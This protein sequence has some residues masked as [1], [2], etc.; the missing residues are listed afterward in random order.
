RQSRDRH[1]DHV[2]A[3]DLWTRLL[4]HRDQRC[5][6]RAA[7]P[8]SERGS[9]VVPLASRHR[10]RG[11]GRAL[12]LRALGLRPRRRRLSRAALNVTMASAIS[13]RGG[14]KRFKLT[15]ERYPSLKERVIHFGRVPSEDFWALR[16]IDFE[17]PDGATVGLLGHNGSGKSTLL[18]CIAGILRPT[19]GEIATR[20]RV[21][22]LLELGAG[23]QGELT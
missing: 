19:D 5:P 14:S 17:V 3:R 21:A 13:V 4:R 7:H 22:A 18:K 10:D 23:F 15:H 12:P 16:G 20:G 8:P 11:V 2:P 9:V 6:Y 1:R